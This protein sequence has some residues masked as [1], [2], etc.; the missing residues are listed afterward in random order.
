MSNLF[1]VI[2][3]ALTAALA[4][5]GAVFAFFGAGDTS[6]AKANKRVAAVSRGSASRVLGKSA[7]AIGESNAKR[8]RQV[9]DTL[10][11]IERKQEQQKTKP[12]LANLLDQADWNITCLL[13]TSPSP[14]D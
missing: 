4:V 8:R 12:T 14:R 2:M 7:E 10:K 5:G 6:N 3:I 13:Y 11:E 9:Q 1:M